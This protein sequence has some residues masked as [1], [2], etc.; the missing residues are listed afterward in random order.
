M[1]ERMFQGQSL[2]DV[3]TAGSPAAGELD[4]IS[5]FYSVFEENKT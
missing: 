4:C 1:F 2:Q 5:A 3:A